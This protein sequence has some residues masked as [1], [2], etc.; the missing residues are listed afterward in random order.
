MRRAAHI[1]SN[2]PE[3][4]EALLA[5]RASVEVRLARIGDGVPDLLVGIRGVTTVM[6]VKDG[7]KPPS[8]RKLTDDEKDWHDAWRG[9]KFVVYSVDDA[10]KALASL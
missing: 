8:R 2:Q 7:K 3:I 5:A 6:E 10:L 1:D 4:V 9:S